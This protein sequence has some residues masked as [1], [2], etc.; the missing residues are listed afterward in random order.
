MPARKQKLTSMDDIA[1]LANVSKP[2][3]SRALKD[4]PLINPETKKRILNLARQHGYSVNWNARKLRTNRSNT[5]AVVMHLPPQASETASAPFFFQLLN[6]VARG[7]WIRHHDVLLCAPES[8]DP[9]SYESMIASKRADGIIFFGQG[10]GDEWLRS[11]ARTRVPFVVWG[12]ADERAAYCTVG[13]DN[14]KGGMLAGKRFAALG[15]SRVL[16]AGNRA[17]PEME[18]RRQGLG[19]GLRSGDRKAEICDLETSDFTLETA[20]RLMRGYLARPAAPRPDAVFA[21]SDSVA[22]GVIIAL[23]EAGVR[24]PAETSVIGYNDLPMA[25]YFEPPLSTIRQDTHQAGSL[26]VEKLFQALEGVKPASATVPTHL[27]IRET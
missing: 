22:M 6:D 13:S 3:V 2:T 15:R 24:I 20:H 27:V 26:L 19:I 7:L 17:H 1:R 4:S 25:Q 14:F 23:R 11:L 8:D 5:V 16:F 10:P 9:Y 12:A 21:G 18:Q